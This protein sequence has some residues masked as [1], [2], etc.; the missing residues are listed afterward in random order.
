MGTDFKSMAAIDCSKNIEKKN[1]FSYLSWPFAHQAMAERDPDFDWEPTFYFVG[2][3]AARPYCQTPAGAFVTVKVK[4]GGKVKSHTYPVLDYRNK[5]IMEP[6]S[7]DVNTSIMRCFVKCCA[8][9]GLGLY[10]YAGEDLPESDKKISPMPDPA[11][12][13]KDEATIASFVSAFVD[14]LNADLDENEVADK[15]FA[16]RAEA[17]ER[18]EI[19]IEVWRRLDS[20]QRSSIKRFLDVANKRRG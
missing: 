19:L 1:G 10:I 3:D 4:F 14:L 7:F 16:L 2:E 6:N 15:M 11:T 13:E 12:T 20:K 18:Q 17:N 8:L 9:F 5:P